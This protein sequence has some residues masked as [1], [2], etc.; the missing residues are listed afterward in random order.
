[1][2][3]SR[4][5][6]WAGPPWTP[7]VNTCKLRNVLCRTFRASSHRRQACNTLGAGRP[8]LRHPPVPR[9]SSAPTVQPNCPESCPSRRRTKRRAFLQAL[10]R[11]FPPLPTPP[12]APRA[13]AMAAPLPP[14]TPSLGVRPGAGWPHPKN[15]RREGRTAL[16][17]ACPG[18]QH[19]PIASPLPSIQ[20]GHTLPPLPQP[21]SSRASPPPRQGALPAAAPR[22]A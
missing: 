21:P 14:L 10:Q 20:L 19:P 18:L 1:M 13:A 17:H 16:A 8:R 9:Q 3:R 2:H 12:A 11:N 15:G 5:V 22:P 7:I 4:A 6:A